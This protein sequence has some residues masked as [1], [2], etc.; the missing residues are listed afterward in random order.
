MGGGVNWEGGAFSW[1]PARFILV[2]QPI[3]KTV[4]IMNPGRLNRSRFSKSGGHLTEPGG[5]FFCLFFL[6]FVI[7]QSAERYGK[8]K[9]NGDHPQIAKN[10]R[11][12]LEFPWQRGSLHHAIVVLLCCFCFLKK[13]SGER[14]GLGSALGLL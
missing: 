3:A 8:E 1:A 14:M 12:E 6:S 5:L 10:K 4:W 9:K 2:L 13:Q 7:H 11:M